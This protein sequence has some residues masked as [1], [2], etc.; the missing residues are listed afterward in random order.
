V[1]GAVVPGCEHGGDRDRADD[2]RIGYFEPG[3]GITDHLSAD[4]TGCG[5]AVN[6]VVSVSPGAVTLDLDTT[7]ATPGDSCDVTITNPDGQAATAN[8]LFAISS[9]HAPVANA[10]GPFAFTCCA[11]FDGPSVLGND[12]DADGDPLTAGKLTDPLHGVR[13]PRRRWHFHVHTGGWLLRGD[14]FSYA[15]DDGQR[16]PVPRRCRSTSQQ[17]RRS[18]AVV[19]A[20]VRQ[21]WRFRRRGTTT[22]PSADAHDNDY[23]DHHDPD[24]DD[25]RDQSSACGRTDGVSGALRLV[26]AKGLR[27]RTRCGESCTLSVKLQL[28]AKDASGS[29]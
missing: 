21:R 12:T 11:P 9:D 2:E 10:D 17:L 14:S 6:G 28:S 25:H 26:L 23:D 4:V 29:A 5:V 27:V 24:Y 19:A 3:S 16:N 8:G 1:S 13:R 18:G 15:A 20:A 22:T 7:G